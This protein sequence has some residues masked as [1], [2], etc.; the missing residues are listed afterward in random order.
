VSKGIVPAVASLRERLDQEWAAHWT[1]AV[2]IHDRGAT[3]DDYRSLAWRCIESYYR[4]FHPFDQATVIG[5]EQ[6]I[7]LVGS[8]LD[9]APAPSRRRRKRPPA[10]ARVSSLAFLVSA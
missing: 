3:P 7:A 2:V 4:R 5:L 6:M 10:C 9:H 8:Q 1:P